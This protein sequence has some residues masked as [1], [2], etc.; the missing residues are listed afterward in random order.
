MNPI[1]KTRTASTPTKRT[2]VRAAAG[3][4]CAALALLAG[5]GGAQAAPRR[6]VVLT[7]PATTVSYGSA[8]LT[9]RVDPEGSATSYYFQYGP[10]SALGDQTAIASAGAGTSTVAVSLALSG[11]APLT[12]Y[13]YRL[14]AINPTGAVDGRLRSFT[15]AKI[16]L[17]LAILAAPN[18]VAFGGQITV[19][20]TLSGTGNAG[21]AV[22]LQANAFP[23]TA[24]FQD[25]GNAELTSAQGTF[26]FTVFS[27]GAA[28]QYRV[29]T[30][31]NPPV[32]SPVTTENVSVLVSSH[33][34]RARRPHHVRVYG[35]VT[36]A[37][38]GMLVLI[39]RISHGH[40]VLVGRAVLHGSAGHSSFSRQVPLRTGIYRVL[41]QVS[42]AQV[43]SYGRPLLI[44]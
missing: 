41:A 38:N 42:G 39:M 18:P 13:H 36:P 5:A 35:T 28:T 32:V 4:A 40:E 33:L 23:F 1:S 19:Q 10:T 17:T 6:P 37:E 14:V 29:A 9:G 44:R 31:T 30:M 11:L 26:T 12:V 7:G 8:T 24:G 22:V 21:R 27:L 15:T 3:A 25:I 34:G 43:A 20:G 16:P 2:C